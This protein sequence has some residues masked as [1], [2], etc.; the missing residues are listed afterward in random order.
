LTLIAFS[1][2]GYVFIGLVAGL[3]NIVTNEYIDYSLLGNPAVSEYDF[4]MGGKY[5]MITLFLLSGGVALAL[6]GSAIGIYTFYEPQN[7]QKYS[8]QRKMKVETTDLNPFVTCDKCNRKLPIGSKFC[9]KC[10]TDITVS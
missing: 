2:L 10:G 1:I 8:K 6:G 3:A 4:R 5:G 7:A 9:P